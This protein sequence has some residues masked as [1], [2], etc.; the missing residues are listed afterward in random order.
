MNFKHW[1]PANLKNGRAFEVQTI[2]GKFLSPS[3]VPESPLLPSVSNNQFSFGRIM[4]T[5]Y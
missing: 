2:L 3:C 5:A 1:L 4:S